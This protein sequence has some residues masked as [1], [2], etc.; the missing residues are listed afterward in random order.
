L[1]NDV[2]YLL[3]ERL[4]RARPERSTKVSADPAPTVVRRRVGRRASSI[5]HAPPTVPML[6]AAIAAP[7]ST[8]P[9]LPE[10]STARRARYHPDEGVEN[11]ISLDDCGP[12][13]Y[14]NLL[15]IGECRNSI[16]TCAELSA[17]STQGSSKARFDLVAELRFG[18]PEFY[19]DTIPI[20]YGV[21]SATLSLSLF[22][23]GVAGPR[24]GD[25]FHPQVAA[26]GDSSWRI[27]GP[28]EE[29][30]LR[31]R[32]LGDDPLCTIKATDAGEVRLE[33]RLTC[34]QLRPYKY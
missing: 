25:Q 33:L 2:K 34:R 7:S 10:R 13:G 17:S 14:Q 15:V 27:V 11:A 30:M 1:T 21:N 31:R 6:R 28:I 5:A 22:N 4:D 20:R 16:P 9:D 32:A 19:V 23:C 18:W 24:L 8:E 29:G 3:R 26:E 12:P